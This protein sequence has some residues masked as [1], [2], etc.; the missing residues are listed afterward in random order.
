M[1]P[2]D[3]RPIMRPRLSLSCVV[4]RR[5]KVRCGR[6]QPAC[7][8]CVRL[9]ETCEYEADALDQSRSRSH[10]QAQVQAPAQVKRTSTPNAPTEE[11]STSR[12]DPA[13]SEDAWANWT[14]R[15]NIPGYSHQTGFDDA[16]ADLGELPKTSASPHDASTSGSG[17]GSTSTASSY[18]TGDSSTFSRSLASPQTPAPT[19]GISFA[20]SARDPSQSNSTTGPIRTNQR[21]SSSAFRKRSRAVVDATPQREHSANDF[22][23]QDAAIH[24]PGTRKGSPAAEETDMLP[25]GHLSVRSGGRVRYVGDAFWGLIKGLVSFPDPAAQS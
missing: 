19:K 23:I 7:G 11:T 9:N 21:P 8:N 2:S 14:E 24:L 25:M 22:W 16:A 17:S 6:E 18:Y 1:L 15:Y 3:S 10:A 13:P 20:F 4:C 12:P 5:R